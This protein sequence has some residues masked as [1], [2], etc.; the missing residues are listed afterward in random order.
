MRIGVS[1]PGPHRRRYWI[2]GG[3]VFWLVTGPLILAGYLAVLVILLLAWAVIS[4]ARLVR[5]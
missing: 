5:R 4:I 3:P 2:S 1:W